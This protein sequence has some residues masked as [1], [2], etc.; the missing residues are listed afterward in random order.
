MEYY[1]MR[2]YLYRKK[3]ITI[4]KFIGSAKIAGSGQI[5]IPK[6]VMR[7]LGLTVGEHI[8]FLKDKN[9]LVY[10]TSKVELP[11]K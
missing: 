2:R 7:E 4:M 11:T 3:K 5:T 10:V 6:D 1:K 8:I 9:G